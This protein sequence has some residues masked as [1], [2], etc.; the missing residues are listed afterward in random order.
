VSDANERLHAV[1]K[2]INISR[3]LYGVPLNGD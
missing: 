3:P 1:D 2:K